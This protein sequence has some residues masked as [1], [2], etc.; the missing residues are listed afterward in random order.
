MDSLVQTTP[1]S[2]PAANNDNSD[3]HHGHHGG[4]TLPPLPIPVDSIQ[5]IDDLIESC[6]SDDSNDYDQDSKS[7]EAYSNEQGNEVTLNGSGLNNK[8]NNLYINGSGNT[9]YRNE[10]ADFNFDAALPPSPKKLRSKMD[11]DCSDQYNKSSATNELDELAIQ[12]NDQAMDLNTS[13]NLVPTQDDNRYANQF[14]ALLLI[15]RKFN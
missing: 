6:D 14:N 7:D 4:R 5:S 3:D 10:N 9:K 15:K 8:Q 13:Q 1:Q 11:S 2:T 12:Q